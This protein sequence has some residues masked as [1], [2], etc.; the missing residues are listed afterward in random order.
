MIEPEALQINYPNLGQRSQKLLSS[1]DAISDMPLEMRKLSPFNHLEQ[2]SSVLFLGLL[3][4]RP[5][6]S[7][8]RTPA[9]FF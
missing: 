4:G 5:I 8:F 7:L 2:L 3:A 1:N 6:I 9:Q